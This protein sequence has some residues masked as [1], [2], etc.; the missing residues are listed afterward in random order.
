MKRIIYLFIWMLCVSNLYAQTDRQLVREGNRH[1]RKGQ[2][3]Q[4]ETSYRKALEKNSRNPQAA[5]NLG[6]ALMSQKN[7]SVAVEQFNNAALLQTD[8]V[9]KA[10][11]YHNIGVIQHQKKNYG[12]AIEAYKQALRL[13]PHDDDTRYNLALCKRQ[14]QKQQQQSGGGS[15]DKQQQD[16]NN[17]DKKDQNKDKN[18]DKKQD[19]KPPQQQPQNERMSRDNAEQLLNAAMQQEKQT[20]ERLK[21]A[22]QQ[23]RR[24]K[25]DKNW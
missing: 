6:C 8:R 11:A 25:L 7:D 16:K 23:P 18:D 19:Q 22:M 9:H 14:Q 21:K 13:N 4:A 15:S 1:F 5:Y 24:R 10:M 2:Y 17:Q 3:A 20:Q 12:A